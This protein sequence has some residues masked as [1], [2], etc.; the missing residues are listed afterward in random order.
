MQK[1]TEENPFEVKTEDSSDDKEDIPLAQRLEMLNSKTKNGHVKPEEHSAVK[2]VGC[3]ATNGAN[4][5]TRKGSSGT[6]ED[7]EKEE[8]PETKMKD[9]INGKVEEEEE[10]E[11][12]NESVIEQ[13]EANPEGESVL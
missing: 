12:V 2:D 8:E 1:R 5:P 6:T 10:V 13:A 4:A 9:S 3:V 11:N 7:V